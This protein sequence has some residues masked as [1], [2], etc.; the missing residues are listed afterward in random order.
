MNALRLFDYAA[1]ANCYKVRLLLA[2]LAVPYER[3][4]VDIFD[5][6]TLDPDFA[7]MNPART[8]PV[9][10]VAPGV[11]LAE[12][13][14]I[15]VYLAEGTELYADD[16]LERAQ[17]LRW[18]LFEQADLVATVGSLR[19]RLLTGR[20]RPDAPGAAKRR[21]GALATLATLEEHLT[22][23]RFL[24]AD[25]YTIADIAMYGYAHVAEEAGID[26]APYPAFEAWLARV[27]EQPGYIND[28]EPYP[29]S[30]H[31]AVSRSIYD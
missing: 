8:T 3:V 22:G 1:S 11:H 29:P 7:R 4:A 10:E 20:L 31:A 25:R 6:D 18:L 17:I 26:T 27:A 5:G 13:N 23:R 2:Q 9:L 16:R 12:S 15:L 19:F 28:L 14:A 30:S 21:Q 24:V